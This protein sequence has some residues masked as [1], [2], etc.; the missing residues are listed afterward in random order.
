MILDYEGK[1][2]EKEI[3]ESINPIFLKPISGT[4][5]AKSKLIRGDNLTVM[6][7]CGVE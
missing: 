2:S 4:P 5:K 1:K 7:Y 6:K 3:L